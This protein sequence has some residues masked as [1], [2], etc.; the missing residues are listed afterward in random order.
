MKVK[1]SWNN[2]DF[3]EMSWHDCTIY[4]LN[5]PHEDQNFIL[6]IDY[7]FKWVLNKENNLFKFWIAPCT[8]T[9]HNTMNLDIKI[10]FSD[11]IGLSINQ[12][13]RE[14]LRESINKKAILYDY[15]IN[16]DKGI[17]TFTSTGFEQIVREQPIF[18]ENINVGRS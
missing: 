12:I 14:N 7:I 1:E 18:S 11:S 9:F 4:S 6:D 5:F 3:E 8:I 17:I 15:T 16:T 2:K 13:R 10:S